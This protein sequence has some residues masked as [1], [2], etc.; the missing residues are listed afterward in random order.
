M[1][2]HRPGASF[3]ISVPLVLNTFSHRR[4]MTT[5]DEFC[6]APAIDSGIR[7]FRAEDALRIRDV[8]AGS[9]SRVPQSR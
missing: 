2:G 4:R 1:L 5:L 7:T 9:K 3:A 8:L 6:N